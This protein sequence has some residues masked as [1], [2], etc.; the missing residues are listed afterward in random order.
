MLLVLFWF[1]LS[2]EES[3]ES[4]MVMVDALGEDVVVAL[5]MQPTVDVGNFAGRYLFMMAPTLMT[6]NAAND[7]KTPQKAPAA[8]IQGHKTPWRWQEEQR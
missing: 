4:D 2:K 3:F 7:A 8:L 5:R 6:I 1:T